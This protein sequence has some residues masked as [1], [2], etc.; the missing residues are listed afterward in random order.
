MVVTCESPTCGLPANY[1]CAKCKSKKL[2][3][4]RYCSS[5]CQAACFESHKVFHKIC[6]NDMNTSIAWTI[7]IAL[8]D[9]MR[10][11]PQSVPLLDIEN[12]L[13]VHLLGCRNFPEMEEPLQQF[14]TL[15]SILKRSL[16]PNLQSLRVV[17]S[18]IE[19]SPEPPQENAIVSI[20]SHQVRAED[21]L[22]DVDFSHGIAVILQP[23]LDPHL[24]SWETAIQTLVENNAFTITSGYSHGGSRL[25]SDAV[26][27]ERIL[28]TY[29]CANIIVPSTSNYAG[30]GPSVR[31]NGFYLSFRGRKTTEDGGEVVAVSR[32]RLIRENQVAFLKDLDYITATFEGNMVCSD[33]CKRV[34]LA[35]EVDRCP[36]PAGATTKDVNNFVMYSNY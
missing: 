26:F 13:L 23:G 14:S 1:H 31:K 10:R 5:I 12:S 33:R 25:T 35:M 28:D 34:L 8:Y 27:D 3:F 2:H 17:I 15:H 16:F 9:S 36:F 7:A 11:N 22:R 24:L 29:F 32:E 19:L 21:I 6:G 4:G 30:Y 20:S 18:G